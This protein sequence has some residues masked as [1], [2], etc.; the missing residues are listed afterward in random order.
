MTETVS[1]AGPE[2]IRFRRPCPVCAARRGRRLAGLR[3]AV[4]DASPLNGE[5]DLAGCPECGLAFYDT[6]QGP[7][8]VEAYYRGHAYYATAATAGAGGQSEADR[9][10]Q[11]DI[12]RRLRLWIGPGF[13]RPIFDLGCGRG[14]LMEA[15]ARAGHEDVFGVDLLPEVVEGLQGRGFRAEAGPLTRLPFP[16]VTPG[17]L[18]YSH[19]LEHAWSPAA[20]LAVARR[21]LPP[22]GLIYVEVPDA[23]RY[24][25][26]VPFRELY[27]EHL[28]HFDPAALEGLLRRAGFE[29]LA[30]DRD[31]F[32]LPGGR[33][34]GVI[35]ALAR[36]GD[37]PTNEKILA[38]RF[39]AGE[40]L[41]H[42]ERYLAA[43][44]AHP[45]LA[46]LD[47]LARSGRPLW[48]WGLSQL[49]MLLAGSTALA[50]G[51]LLGFI[52][53]DPF[54]TRQTVKGLPVRPP[55]SLAGRPAEEGVLLAVPGQGPAMRARL[56]ELGFSG[57]SWVLFD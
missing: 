36:K 29:P 55:E 54:K 27:L 52:D 53:R 32:H 40:G 43:S 30:L 37:E 14:G 16:D 19:V 45:A 22:D 13:E 20:A 9:K 18:I 3:F 24:D 42:L 11:A 57:P 21:R 48:I 26:A 50:T 33:A 28:G 8:A 46:V 51:G 25:P 39:P 31:L 56:A 41:N 15:L 49:T 34:D 4:F 10:H 7:E 35:W 44:R 47:D 38:T 1:Q 17:L 12:L 6:D 23:S 5:I 2:E